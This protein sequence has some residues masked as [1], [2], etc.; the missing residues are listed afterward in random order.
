[1]TATARAAMATTCRATPRKG[2]PNLAIRIGSMARAGSRRSSTR[3]FMASAPAIRRDGTWPTCRPLRA[4]PYARYQMTS[5]E[6]D[7]IHDVIEFLMVTA[8][9]PGDREAA[10]RGAKIFAEK[11][12][13][14]DCHSADAQGD[15]RHRSPQSPRQYLALR[16]RQP[17]GHLRYGGA[18]PQRLLPAL[19]RAVEP[20]HHP[21][22]CGDDLCGSHPGTAQANAQPSAPAAGQGG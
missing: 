11:G 21:G 18:G 5:L 9:K 13:C 16:Q 4:I 15:S 8:G 3:S 19:V 1:M 7:E 14:F 17:R 22:A 20:G 10:Q 2:I 12:Q 6:P